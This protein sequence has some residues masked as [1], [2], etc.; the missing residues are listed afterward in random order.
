MKDYRE[1]SYVPTEWED[2][3]L[4]SQ[5]GE[6]LVEGTPI[7]EEYLGNLE[8]GT[9][10]SHLDIGLLA[11][12]AMQ[13]GNLNQQEI[14]KF[15]KQRILQGRETISNGVSDNGY[16][17]DSEPFKTISF[18]GFSQI[19]APNYDVIITPASSSD[20]GNVGDLIVYDKTQNGFKVKMTGSAKSVSFLWT[21]INPNV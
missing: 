1:Q 8:A 19:N 3:V 16:F 2:E 21:L 5:T 9:L 18:K 11:N 6:P 17:R 10:L 14:E 15:K 20:L 7:S 4:D 12:M 13:L